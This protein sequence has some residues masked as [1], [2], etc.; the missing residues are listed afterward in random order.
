MR[1]FLRKNSS[2]L[3]HFISFF[4]IF[5]IYVFLLTLL[6]NEISSIDIGGISFDNLSI[7]LMVILSIFLTLSTFSLFNSKRTF[8]LRKTNYGSYHLIV[9]KIIYFCFRYKTISLRFIPIY[10][11]LR[12]IEM[13][14]FEIKE[15]YDNISCD[16]SYKY[17][18]STINL[19]AISNIVNILIE[20]TYI[21]KLNELPS[22]LVQQTIYKLTRDNIESKDRVYSNHIIEVFNSILRDIDS[23]IE[24]VNL[25][26]NTNP[27]TTLELAKRCLFNGSRKTFNYAVF[28]YNLTNNPPIWQG[29]KYTF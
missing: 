21:I 26:M 15:I 20:D 22:N 5:A 4:F 24:V 6:K 16:N 10:C 28:Q 19:S 9:W 13:N 8:E 25:F 7:I 23:K 1:F 18:V 11:Q 3:T 12:I 29:P 2:I 14:L 27:I 17:T